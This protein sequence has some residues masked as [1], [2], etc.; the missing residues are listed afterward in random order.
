MENWQGAFITATE[1]IESSGL[2]AIEQLALRTILAHAEVPADAGQYLLDQISQNS[3]CTVEETLRT[4]R[5]D[6]RSLALKCKNSEN[7]LL[8]LLSLDCY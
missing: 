5:Q 4:I 7:A 8:E 3:D 1:T 2:S 6:V